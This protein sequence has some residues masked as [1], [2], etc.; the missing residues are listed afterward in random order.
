MHIVIYLLYM[1]IVAYQ[2]LKK[3]MILSVSGGS[4]LDSR[5]GECACA[6]CTQK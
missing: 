1:Y 2:A 6:L 4:D 5:G 3:N